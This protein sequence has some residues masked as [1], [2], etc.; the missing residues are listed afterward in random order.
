[1][2]ETL[3]GAAARSAT[4]WSAHDTPSMWRMLAPQQTEAHWRHVAGLRKLTE[5]TATHMARL[6]VY[7]DNL[8]EAW[9]PEKS[10]AARTFIARLDYLDQPR[11]IHPRGSGR[12]L[13][14]LLNSDSDPRRGSHEGGRHQR[15]V[16][17]E[18]SDL[19]G[20]RRL[21]RGNEGLA[22]ARHDNR[23]TT[24]SSHG[25]GEIERKGPHRDGGPKPYPGPRWNPISLARAICFFRAP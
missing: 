4:D 14:R 15:G 24:D 16:C 2:R 20:L 21:D 17:G 12:Q 23:P 6:Q 19:E 7:R 25:L 1:M 5:L 9:P 13:Q 3:S 10:P 8:A 18:A 11:P 22:S